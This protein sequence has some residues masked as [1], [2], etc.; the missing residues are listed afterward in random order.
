LKEIASRARSEKEGVVA[1]LHT[2][3]SLHASQIAL[4]DKYLKQASLLEFRLDD[5]LATAARIGREIPELKSR[6]DI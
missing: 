6:Q 3:Q 4:I 5:T 2:L 1:M